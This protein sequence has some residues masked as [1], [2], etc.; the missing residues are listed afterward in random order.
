MRENKE[1]D[2]ALM[3]LPELLNG[4]FDDRGDFQIYAQNRVADENKFLDNLMS[5]FTRVKEAELGEVKPE[6]LKAF[7]AN[8]VRY[9]DEILADRQQRGWEKTLRS[10]LK[11]I[12]NADFVGGAD[13]KIVI[14]NVLRQLFPNGWDNPV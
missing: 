8:I 3:S 9:K 2:G 6:V 4:E 7:A 14:G 11:R 1:K 13:Q 10:M 12:E 5:Q